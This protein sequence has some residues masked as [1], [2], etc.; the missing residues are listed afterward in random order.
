MSPASRLLKVVVER[1]FSP[2]EISSPLTAGS[3]EYL[4]ILGSRNDKRMR[5]PAGR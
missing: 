4:V 2:A 3:K 1:I 5:A